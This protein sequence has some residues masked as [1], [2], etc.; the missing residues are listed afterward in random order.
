MRLNA[1]RIGALLR[2]RPVPESPTVEIDLPEDVTCV[3]PPRDAKFAQ[4]R[5]VRIRACRSRWWW[6]N[7]LLLQKFPHQ[8]ERR[9]AVSPGLN[10]DV[11]HLAF[12]VHGTPDV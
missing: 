10:E 12:A 9:L 4:R 1:A 5:A 6:S 11:Q 3:V 2:S 7:A 8:L